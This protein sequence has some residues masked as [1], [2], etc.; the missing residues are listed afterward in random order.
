MAIFQLNH[1]VLFV[2]DLAE[3]VAF[4]R[5]VLGF[6]AVDMG[7]LPGAAF[8]RAP[9]STNDHDLGL[10]EVPGPDRRTPA[11]AASAC[12]TWRGRSTRS[13]R[14]RAWPDGS[15]GP[16]RWSGCPTTAR[17]RACTA[18][19]R[20][21]S[22]SRSCGSSRPPFTDA[23]REARRRIGALDLGREIERFGRVTRGGVGVSHHTPSPVSAE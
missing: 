13:T 2:R 10:F 7:G 22:S 12:T 23:D 15:R 20:T 9:D 5:D 11:A 4:Y 8:L 6:S 18:G 21:A 17:P 19:T 1:A 16:T 14:S 3:S